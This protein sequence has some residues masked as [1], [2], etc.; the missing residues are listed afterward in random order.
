MR[1]VQLHPELAAGDFQLQLFAPPPKPKCDLLVKYTSLAGEHT[2]LVALGPEDVPGLYEPQLVYQE[3]P[4]PVHDP[5]SEPTLFDDLLGLKPWRVSM[6][7]DDRGLKRWVVWA[8]ADIYD[9]RVKGCF[10][11]DDSPFQI[12]GDRR[13]NV[14]IRDRVF[15]LGLPHLYFGISKDVMQVWCSNE[16]L[17]SPYDKVRRFRFM[18]VGEDGFICMGKDPPVVHTSQRARSSVLEFFGSFFTSDV[19]E[20]ERFP[21]CD[22]KYRKVGRDMTHLEWTTRTV[23]QK[24]ALWERFTKKEGMEGILNW[25]WGREVS[26]EDFVTGYI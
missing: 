2:E 5:T 20:F 8:P 14:V 11:P 16:R 24:A 10:V 3:R 17:V 23:M 22:Y 21:G 9:I 7:Y 26:F 4:M 1:I 15:R 13:R 6:T 12:N 19:V 25:K 18:N